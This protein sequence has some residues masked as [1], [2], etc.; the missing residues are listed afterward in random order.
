[1]TTTYEAITKS[2]N[3]TEVSIAT[4]EASSLEAARKQLDRILWATD[5]ED[6]IVRPAAG[7]GWDDHAAAE[8][9]RTHG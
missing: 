3:G 2:K 7:G 8:E 6:A 4:T 1:M 5:C 9:S